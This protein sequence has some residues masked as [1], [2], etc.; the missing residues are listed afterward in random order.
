MENYWHKQLPG[1][2]LFSDL[3][4]SRPESKR[5]AGK[6]LII[7]GNVHSFSAVGQAHQAATAA[8]IGTIRIILPDSLQKTVSKLLP[9]ADFAP[10]TPSGSFSQAALAIFLDN[11]AWADGVLLAGDFGR[12]S[13]TSIVLEKFVSKF[14]GQLVL[15]KDSVDYFS[16]LPKAVGN[17]PNTCLIV[18]MAQL[19]QMASHLNSSVAFTFNLNLMQLVEKLHQFTETYRVNLIL[20]HLDTMFVAVDGRISTTPTDLKDEDAWRIAIAAQ[21]SVWWLQNPSKPFESLTTSVTSEQE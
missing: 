21:A 19:Q 10:S 18:T 20:K 3:L 11:A 6:L 9:E 17:R 2:P 14:Q 8:G 12:N 15:T 1:K 4:W 5:T 7:G 13:E 16:Q